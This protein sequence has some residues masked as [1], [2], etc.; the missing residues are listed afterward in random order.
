M[1]RITVHIRDNDG[2]IREAT[3]VVLPV[4]GEP[5]AWTTQVDIFRTAGGIPEPQPELSILLTDSQAAELAEALR[6]PVP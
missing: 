5:Q 3:A 6:N 2:G 1:G 4:S